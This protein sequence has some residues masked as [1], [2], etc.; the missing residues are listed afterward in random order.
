M[1][2]TGTE[3]VSDVLFLSGFILSFIN[4]SSYFFSTGLEQDVDVSPHFDLVRQVLTIRSNYTIDDSAWST[5]FLSLS[6]GWNMLNATSAHYISSTQVDQMRPLLPTF[7]DGS[8]SWNT[9][10]GCSST[11]TF[12]GESIL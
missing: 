5:P 11:I 8:Y 3:R 7:H 4:R 6:P 9:H 12:V 10:A 2:S 1:I